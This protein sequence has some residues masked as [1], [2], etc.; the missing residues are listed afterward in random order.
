M[1]G[2]TLILLGVVAGVI[3]GNTPQGRKA[4]KEAGRRVAGLWRDPRVQARVDDLQKG[5]A[6]VPGVGPDLAGFIDSARP[7]GAS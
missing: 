7:D 6:K 1:R 3:I 2:R 4:Y 5:V